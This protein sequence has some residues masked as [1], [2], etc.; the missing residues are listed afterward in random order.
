MPVAHAMGSAGTVASLRMTA[1]RPALR[2][3]DAVRVLDDRDL[4]EVLGLLV[5]DP[6][7]NTV[8]AARV[9]AARTLDGT[10]LGGDV[11]GVGDPGQLSAV[12]FCGGNLI[13]IGG[14]FASWTVLGRHLANRRRACSSIVGP[15]SAV[16]ILWPSLSRRWGTAR[17]IRAS[18]P[19]LV[20]DRVPSLPIDP[21]VRPAN[22]EDVGRYLPA[23]F[24]MFE[25]EL[26]LTPADSADRPGYRVRLT[27]LIAAGHA[28][29]RLDD[30]GA[31]LFK[32]ELAAVSSQCCQVQGVWVRPDMRGRGVGTGA[33]AAVIDYALQ[34]APRVSLYVNDFNYPA[35][36]LYERLGMRQI[37]TLSTVL[38]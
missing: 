29:V 2:R 24:A 16:A 15:A 8:V 32:A 14:D 26:G 3:R 4:E 25:E 20:T 28:L 7:A 31:V 38:F 27:Q 30:R 22:F 17:M 1:V 6:V 12:A 23:A 11:V 21:A 33:M 5:A 35:R 34:L 9:E 13:P 36:R 19:L 10:R 37:G 18:Q